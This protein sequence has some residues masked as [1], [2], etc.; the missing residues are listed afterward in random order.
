ME[1]RLNRWLGAVLGA[2]L[3]WFAS[4]TCLA[5][6]RRALV[7]GNSRY[8]HVT[9]LANP[10]H[11][12]ELMAV[13][14]KEVGFKVMFLR[15]ATLREMADGA[16]Q[17]GRA[18][19]RGDI[20]FVY[21]AGHGVQ[22]AAENFL[23]PVDAEVSVPAQL[24]QRA[25]PLGRLLAAL[26]VDGR[27]ASIVVLDACRNNPFVERSPAYSRALNADS[28]GPAA[29]A[30]GLSQIEQLPGNTLLAFATAPGKVALDGAGRHSPYAEALADVIRG[31]GLEVTSVFQEA[32]LRVKRSTAF[33][34]EPWVNWSLNGQV[35]L[36]KR[37]GN[38]IIF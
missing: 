36:K 2:L 5:Q 15:D 24:R 17:F 8:A 27:A 38:T 7:I 11:D 14:L 28:P 13:S 30:A 35:F 23:I 21:F 18:I 29:P 33:R 37:K 25:Y 12:A 32:T 1:L 34:Q 10:V 22:Y 9:P 3:A 31:E 19:G 16:E 4:S 6:E 20:V 26:P